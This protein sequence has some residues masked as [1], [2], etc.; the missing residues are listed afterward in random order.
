MRAALPLGLSFQDY[1]EEDSHAITVFIPGCRRGCPGCQNPS[2]AGEGGEGC[3]DISARILA[4]VV[5]ASAKRN[6]TD[7]VVLTGG[8]PLDPANVKST[9]ELLGHL[10]AKGLSVAIYTGAMPDEV[11]ASGITGF[12]YVKCGPFLESKKN[13][14]AGKRKNGRPELASINQQWYSGAMIPLN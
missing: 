4:E 1:P 14:A 11:K 7:K 12:N 9:K 6:Y 8:D 10:K 13:P 5:A 3:K 2:L